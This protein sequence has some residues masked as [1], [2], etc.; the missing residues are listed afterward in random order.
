MC[1]HKYWSFS[2][3]LSGANQVISQQPEKVRLADSRYVNS[4]YNN[5]SQDI[6]WTKCLAKN[7]WIFSINQ[8][9][10]KQAG[11]ERGQ[12]Q[13][14]LELGYTLLRIYYIK[15]INKEYYLL[16][17][18]VGKWGGAVSQWLWCKPQFEKNLPI[19]TELDN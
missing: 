8:S 1:K 9:K 18:K 14:K 6:I 4:N 16:W 5:I 2:H 10:W 17:R 13:L 11:A 15:V 12:D 3:V 19:G 7:L